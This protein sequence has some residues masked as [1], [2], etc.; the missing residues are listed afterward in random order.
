MGTKRWVVEYETARGTRRRYFDD[1][2]EAFAGYA[3]LVDRHGPDKVTLVLHKQGGARA[4]R[5]QEAAGI[6]IR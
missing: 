2:A 6:V 4:L 3:R 5:T 1:R